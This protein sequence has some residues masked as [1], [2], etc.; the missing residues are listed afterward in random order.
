MSYLTLMA[1]V[2]MVGHS[3]VGPDLPGMTEAA[4][5]AAGVAGTVA[6]QVINGAPLQ[7]N[8]DHGAEAEGV[9]ARAE[10]ALGQTDVLI[11]TEAQPLAAQIEW[12]DSAGAVADW[13]GAAWGANPA[14]EVF[15]YETWA[16]LQSGPGSL[17][18]DDPGARLP[19]RERLA[20]DLPRWQSLVAA[21]N[22][23]RPQDAPP[24][25]LIPA[26]QAMG[27]LA[28]A[29]ARGEVP[30]ASGIADFFDDDIHL[31]GRGLYFVALVQM[32]AITGKT[33]EGLPPRLG[34][35]WRDRTS[36][37]SPEMAAVLQRLA[38]QAVEAQPA[39]DMIAAPVA[40]TRPA[41]TAITNRNLS[42]GLAGIADWSA[43][44]PFLNVMKTARPWI[45]HKP[46]Q[47]GGWE[48]ADLQVAGHVDAHGW[49]QSIPAGAA[50]LSTLVLTDLPTSAGGVAGRYVLTWTGKGDLRLE[51]RA[52]RQDQ[53]PGRITFDYIPGP[54]SVI[55]TLTALDSADP[56]RDLVL[57]RADRAA[58]LAAGQV[59]NPDWLA[60]LQGVRGVRF[61]D[62]MATNNATLAR[63]VDRPLPGDFTYA[64]HGAPME[65][66]V[67]LANRLGADPWFTIP[68]LAED[69]LVRDLAMVSHDGLAPGLRASV[70]FSNEVW[71]WQ[72][73]QARWADAAAQTRWG[74][75]DAWVQ[76]YA[77]RAAEV[78]DIWA[79]VYGAD[80]PTRL[81][82]VI[83]TQTGWLGLED[84][85]LNAPL[86]LAE[87]R[88]APRLSFDAYAVT[89]YFAASLGTPEKAPLV[90]AW[91]AASLVA[92]E[93]RA[94]SAGLTGAA[95]AAFL[96]AHRFD[97]AVALA[98]RELADGSVT[99]TPQDT[100]IAL[101]GAIW[102][103]HKAAAQTAGLRLVMYEGGTHVVG[104]GP[105]ADDPELTAFFTH[106]NYAPA[107]GAL[108]DRLLADWAGMTD[109]PFN[110]F[111]DVGTPTKWGSWGALRHLGDDNPR[112]Q[113]LARGCAGC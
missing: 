35:L 28:D 55:V 21:A 79:A 37:V 11:L 13:A 65:V 81:T 20:D 49:P 72:F 14:T 105:V 53:A 84:Q 22:A 85:I 106:L 94:D 44:Q 40:P 82:R 92:A 1:K 34:R 89:G 87:G 68:H 78:A 96:G 4:M 19:W 12:N 62:W 5:A 27:L 60:R 18:P 88:P 46:G 42:L 51:G 9:N 17:I 7:W 71:N 75:K 100:L 108:Y 67:A 39:T 110:A 73:G 107:M 90:K 86:V 31:N 64:L 109:A 30:G 24:A 63:A 112:W 111:V 61:M 15:L 70:E 16:S 47:W 59:F 76:A 77:L 43:Q 38:R 33:P 48:F 95:R 36:I 32:A 23:L 50:G 58:A 10:L 69:A 99:G 104:I 80:A 56:I 97:D 54:G 91:L 83:S 2:L 45:G 6:A 3:L 93:A 26:G 113:S 74:A 29:V 98:A 41:L 103:H 25:R 52:A 101:S 66:M 102:P 57:V 8:W